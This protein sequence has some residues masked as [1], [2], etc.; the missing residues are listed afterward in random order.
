[1][2][3]E[4]NKWVGWLMTRERSIYSRLTSATVVKLVIGRK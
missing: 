1:M 4:I 3:K 2:M